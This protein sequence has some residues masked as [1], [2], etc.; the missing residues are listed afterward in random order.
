[1]TSC[2]RISNT[3]QTWSN[4]CLSWLIESKSM[5][6]RMVSF[7]IFTCYDAWN[8]IIILKRSFWSI[9]QLLIQLLNFSFNFSF[10]TEW[11]LQKIFCSNSICLYKV[12]CLVAKTEFSPLFFIFLSLRNIEVGTNGIETKQQT[13]Q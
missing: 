8:Y 4:S 2:Q 13:G 12:D 3:T 11:A 1:M 10:L 9:I 7:Y 6:T 5:K